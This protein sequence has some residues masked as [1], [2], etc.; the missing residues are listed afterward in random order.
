MACT[1]YFGWNTN[2]KSVFILLAK[3]CQKN[4]MKK[5]KWKKKNSGNEVI[6][7]GEVSIF[8]AKRGK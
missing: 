5:L 3:F 6:L 1:D 4:E 7:G 2:L 8:F